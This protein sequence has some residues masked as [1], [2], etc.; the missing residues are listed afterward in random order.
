MPSFAAI[1]QRFQDLEDVKAFIISQCIYIADAFTN[2]RGSMGSLGGMSC[3]TLFISPKTAW[4]LWPAHHCENLHN[5]R[6]TTCDPHAVHFGEAQ[7]DYQ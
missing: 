2:C 3:S 5:P 4:Q 6:E 7:P 1:L